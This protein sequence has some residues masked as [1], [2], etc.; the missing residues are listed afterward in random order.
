VTEQAPRLHV[1]TKSGKIRVSAEPGAQI[2]VEGGSLQTEQDGTRSVYVVRGSGTVDVRCPEGTEVIVGT[3]SGTVELRGRVGAARIATKSGRIDVAH[4]ESVDARTASGRVEIERCDGECRIAVVSG[5]VHVG[6]AGH[7]SVSSVSGRISV[8]DVDAADVKNVSGTIELGASATGRVAVRSVSGTVK[9]S[10][11]QDRSP[12]TRLRSVSG[13]VRCDCEQGG[14][15][16]LDVK[17]IS[18]TIR[19]ACS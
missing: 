7:A 13:S 18:G 8:D 6:R 2:A 10:V 11:P 19:V 1:A 16:E 9:I 5:T 4:C 14:D 15:G 12:A 17:T 3:S